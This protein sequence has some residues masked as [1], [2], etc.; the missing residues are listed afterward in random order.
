[1][2]PTF[3]A[4]RR[5]L[6]SLYTGRVLISMAETMVGIFL[7]IFIFELFGRQLWSVFLFYFIRHLVYAL[8]VPFGAIILDRVGSRIPLIL[9]VSSSA[10]FIASLYMVTHTEGVS[11]LVSLGLALLFTI[12]FRIFFWVPFH[13]DIASHTSRATRGKETGIM[14]AALTL[15]SATAPAI[16]GFLIASYGYP[17]LFM[18]SVVVGLAAIIP[19][20]SVPSREETFSWKYSESFRRL[21]APETRRLSVTS[22]ILGAENVIGVIVWPLFIFLLLDGNYLE[23]GVIS[24]LIVVGTAVFQLVVGDMLDKRPKIGVLRGWTL[25]TALAWVLKIFVVTAFQIFIVG[26]YHSIVRSFRSVSYEAFFYE[27]A[28]DGGQYVDEYTVVNEIAIQ[29][30]K[31]LTIVA[32]AII[33]AFFGLQW[34]F[35]IGF[36][37]SLV[38]NMFLKQDTEEEVRTHAKEVERRERTKEKVNRKLKVQRWHADM[39]DFVQEYAENIYGTKDDPEQIPISDESYKR[40]TRINPDT[41]LYLDDGKG[42]VL[43]WSVVLPTTRTLA[44][45]FID[46]E[47]SERELF[48]RTPEGGIY[49][50]LYICSIITLPEHRRKGYATVLLKDAIARFPVANEYLFADGWSKEGKA[51]IHIAQEKGYDVKVRK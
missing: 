19:F 5:T 49:D 33:A 41:L 23:V 27:L 50:A 34:T 14:L 47:I 4:E 39:Y 31:V 28:A 24:S 43:S 12:L 51:M 20:I 11:Q 37:T 30:G 36:V 35:L 25:F 48:D 7:A 22:I 46:G 44:D 15:V 9:G 1:M 13:V 2:I 17:V 32:I 29:F 45:L 6:M 21:F 26:A 42:N 18:V 40:I 3:L 10:L 8:T 16:G 38:L